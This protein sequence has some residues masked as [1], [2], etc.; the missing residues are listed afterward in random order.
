MSKGHT[1]W[2]LYNPIPDL[3]ADKAEL[4]KFFGNARFLVPYA[5][6]GKK[7]AHATLQLL[8]DLNDLSPVQKATVAAKSDFCFGNGLVT[9]NGET[10]NTSEFFD[11]LLSIGISPE[12]IT[13]TARSS[14]RDEAACGTTFILARIVEVNGQWSASIKNV[15][16]THCL[17]GYDYDN[18]NSDF[19]NTVLF[20]DRE[21]GND[22]TLTAGKLAEWKIVGKWPRVTKSGKVFETMFQ[23]NSVGYEK[24]FWGRPTADTNWL[25]I[26]YQQ[27]NSNAKISASEVTAKLLLLMKEPDPELLERAGK[28]AEE[29]K[30]AITTSVRGTMTNK[31]NDSQSLAAIFYDSDVPEVVQVQINRDY[32]YTESLRKIAVQNICA[33]HGIPAALVGL[34]EMRVGLGGTVVMDTLI[35]TNGM[36]IV[37]T[38]KRFARLFQD[39]MTFFG[40]LAGFDMST[41]QIAFV[42]PI[43]EMIAQL[44]AVRV[45]TKPE[46]T[47]GNETNAAN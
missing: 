8:F 36:K 2:T 32:Q 5:V 4:V 26:D 3:I 39:V 6:Q 21:I 22:F 19:N 30:I 9:M 27:A 10:D 7:T 46:T 20:A 28:S 43:P 47:T 12:E 11:F 23:L 16:P 13:D 41:H 38:Q 18:R 14:F 34:E 37:P 40:G 29:V 1:S 42:G 24:N 45:T 31:G 33:A 35:K 17:P 15:P 25:Y 44:Q